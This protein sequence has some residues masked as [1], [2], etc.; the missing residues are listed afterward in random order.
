MSGLLRGTPKRSPIARAIRRTLLGG[1]FVSGACTVVPP[2]DLP[3]LTPHRPTIARD[4]VLPRLDV[5]LSGLPT[6]GFSVPVVVENGT[7]AFCYRVFLDFDPYN[8]GQIRTFPC[9]SPDGEVTLVSFSLDESSIDPSFCH[10]IEFAVAAEFNGDVSP[11]TPTSVGG[12]SVTWLYDSTGGGG[13]PIPYDAGALGDAGWS[14]PDAPSD[15]ILVS[16][17]SGSEP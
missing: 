6:G 12:D 8:P 7:D 17:E 2:P 1:V 3:S 10:R 16:P 4:G 13:C 5:I 9:R 11:H 14:M 15:A